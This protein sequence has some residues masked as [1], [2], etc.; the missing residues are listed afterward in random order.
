MKRSALATADIE[1]RQ[2]V[3]K[4][5]KRLS[6]S[7]KLWFGMTAREQTCQTGILDILGLAKSLPQQWITLGLKEY[8]HA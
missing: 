8:G 7:R 6:R 2:K 5:M 1:T 3:R 4:G